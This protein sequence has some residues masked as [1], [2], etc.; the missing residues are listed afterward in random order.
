[1][2][3]GMV[4]FLISRYQ[5]VRMRFLELT[6]LP[7]SGATPDG[8]SQHTEGRRAGKERTVSWGGTEPLKSLETLHLWTVR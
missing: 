5:C 2:Q 4:P 1:M 3:E 6:P 8:K 7:L